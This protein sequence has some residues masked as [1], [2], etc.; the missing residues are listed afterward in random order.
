MYN[1]LKIEVER[2]SKVFHPGDKV[3][4]FF[5]IQSDPFVVRI[6]AVT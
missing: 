6:P 4:E 1:H 3:Y 5:N 2:E